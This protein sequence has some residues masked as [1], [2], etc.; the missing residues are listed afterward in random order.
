MLADRLR[1]SFLLICGSLLFLYLDARFHTAG[2][3]GL[4]LIPLLLFFVYGTA[5]DLC[6]LLGQAG[7]PVH[8]RATVIGASLVALSPTVPVIWNAVS[9]R[10]PN[11]LSAYPIDCPIGTMGWI[12]IA[13]VISVTSTF[14]LEMKSYSSHSDGDLVIR[15]LVAGSFIAAYVGGSM[16][17]LVAIRSLGSGN[18][19]LAALLTMIATTKS[20]DIGAYF[21][22]KAIGK[23]KL[24][25]RLSPGKTWEGAIGGIVFATVAATLCLLFLFPRV[26]GPAMTDAPSGAGTGFRVGSSEPAAAPAVFSAADLS[27]S[28]LV[29]P[30][31]ALPP[32]VL[33]FI[34]GPALAISGM[35]GD[36]AESLIKRA[37]NAKD[38]G[39]WLPGMGGVWDVTDS[40][41]FAA[42][43]AFL[44]F[45]AAA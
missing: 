45:V 14:L 33:A 9:N 35:V 23:H 30:S 43:P 8:R 20:T 38:S 26:A 19:G 32:L 31:T 28:Q 16:A 36:L 40:L 13:L 25:P 1:T 2:A 18:W 24:I 44:C 6:G 42:L 29:L 41:I 12:A 15:R 22:G 10:L 4:Y 3:G 37:C 39:N 11:Q 5:S 21:T 17:F 27:A 34:L 7:F